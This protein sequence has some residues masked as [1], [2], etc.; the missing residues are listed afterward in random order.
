MNPR[1]TKLNRY[2]L[3]AFCLF[4]VGCKSAPTSRYFDQ[5]FECN[6][7]AGYKNQDDYTVYLSNW[8]KARDYFRIE[9]TTKPKSDIVFVGNSLIM[10]FHKSHLDRE[11]PNKEI[12]NRGIGGDMTDLLLERIEKD[13]LVLEPK[14]IVLEIGG[15]DLIQKKCLPRI[16]SN[17]IK[18]HNLIARKLPKTK[19]IHMG[20]PP[21]R[22]AE[23][24][25]ISP[26]LNAFL[27]SLPSQYP[28][29]IFVDTWSVM[30]DSRN[31]ILGEEYEIPG[32]LIHFNDKG[33]EVWGKLIRRYL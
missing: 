18:I 20:I 30:R 31:P 6:D 2:T 11:F 7:I 29:V 33:Y 32:D 13:A 25:M 24:N 10:L 1:I 19:V 23:L 4:L 9:N 21:T 26:V 14:V 22:A 12:A 3:I 28:N 15:N 5:S 8:Q 17:I 27:S 16:E